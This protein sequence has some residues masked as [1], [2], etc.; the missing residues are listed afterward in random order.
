LRRMHPDNELVQQLSEGSRLV[1]SEP[2]GN[3]A[4]AWNPMPEGAYGVVKAD[5]STMSPFAPAAP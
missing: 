3:L 5:T 1:V 4:G 2:L